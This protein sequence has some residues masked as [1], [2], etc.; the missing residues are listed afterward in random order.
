MKTKVPATPVQLCFACVRE[1]E[2]GLT[3][4]SSGA[5]P[6]THAHALT[7]ETEE[8]RERGSKAPKNEAPEAFFNLP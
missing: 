7:E 8:Q 6:Q 2:S 4:Q 1:K 5:R 3:G